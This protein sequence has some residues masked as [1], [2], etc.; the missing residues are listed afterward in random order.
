MNVDVPAALPA[1]T[2]SYAIFMTDSRGMAVS[3]NE[4]V[5]RIFGYEEGEFVDRISIRD[6]F[7]A[8]DFTA[9]FAGRQPTEG[10]PSPRSITADGWTMRKSGLPVWTFAVVTEMHNPTG[11]PSGYHVIVR[12]IL[13]SETA[14]PQSWGVR[15]LGL[16]ARLRYQ[17]MPI[18]DIAR[19]LSTFHD[20]TGDVSRSGQQLL[21][22]AD[23]MHACL[24]DIADQLATCSFGHR[25]RKSSCSL[26]NVVRQCTDAWKASI[27][28]AGKELCTTL[29]G[30]ALNVDIDSVRLIEVVANVMAVAEELSPHAGKISVSCAREG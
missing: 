14:E 10:Y 7:F 21:A 15:F 6:L 27:A 17:L 18:Y 3:W 4:G 28:E 23:Q 9:A 16:L 2:G 25:A 20:G 13:E 30:D 19:H 5:R 11:Q 8:G 12:E 1:E 26:R 22:H 24:G 29:A